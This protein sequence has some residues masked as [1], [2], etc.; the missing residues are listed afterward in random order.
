ME[1]R[2]AP[3]DAA[4]GQT[5]GRGD[6]SKNDRLDGKPPLELVHPDFVTAV[7]R[8]AAYGAAKY[9]RWNWLRG[10]E[11]SRDYGA[12]LRHLMAWASGEDLDPESG[13]PHLAH[14]AAC[15]MIVYVTQTRGLGRD[16]RLGKGPA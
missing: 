10:K 2:I 16:D 8:V 3:S 5:A 15:V 6:A 13:L 7:A 9:G 4:D 11:L 12:A 14:A 1:E